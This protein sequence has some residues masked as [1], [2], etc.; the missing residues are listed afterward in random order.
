MMT[1]RT[2][3][4][5]IV[6]LV[7]AVGSVAAETPTVSETRTPESFMGQRTCDLRLRDDLSGFYAEPFD[8]DPTRFEL[9]YVTA[10]GHGFILLAA[11]TSETDSCGK[12]VAAVE[13]EYRLGDRSRTETISFH[14]AA[15]EQ[16]YD[17]YK[18]YVGVF[19]A[20]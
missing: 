16:R 8:K 13:L 18:A 11:V 12:I 15:L 9:L 4:G 17:R 19:K 3:Q 5:S 14:C 6:A 2:L 20:D 7:L 10:G 1:K